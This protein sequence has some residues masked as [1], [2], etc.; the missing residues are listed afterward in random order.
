M[1]VSGDLIQHRKTQSLHEKTLIGPKKAVF[2]FFQWSM[3]GG[4]DPG[5]PLRAYATASQKRK[6]SLF[7][8]R[9]SESFSTLRKL[10]STE[11]HDN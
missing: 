4:F 5:T 7:L 3:G 2:N 6:V 10:D 9:H 1:K 8:L 11:K